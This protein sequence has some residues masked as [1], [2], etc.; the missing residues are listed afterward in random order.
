MGRLNRRL[1]ASSIG[2]RVS[3]RTLGVPISSVRGLTGIG[4]RS[5]SLVRRRRR[6]LPVVLPRRIRGRLCR[7][8]CLY[9]LRLLG[10]SRCFRLYGL[11]CSHRL[12]LTSWGSMRSLLRYMGVF[13]V[14]IRELIH[15]IRHRFII[16]FPK[17][18]PFKSDLLSLLRLSV[19]CQTCV[20]KM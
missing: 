14:F 5:R 13:L 12:G 10:G 16:S 11:R 8:L 9:R 1:A 18:W 19:V 15:R 20:K 3:I 6:T 7:R 17:Q 4:I 2:R